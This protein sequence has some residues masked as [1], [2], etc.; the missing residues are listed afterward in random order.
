M[1][2]IAVIFGGQSV[3]HDVSIVTALSSVI[4][5]LELTKKYHVVAVYIAKDGAWYSDEALKDITIYTSG[6]IQ[7]FLQKNTPVSVALDGG[8]SFVKRGRLSEKKQK[9][10]IVFPAMH[11]T[12]GEDGALMGMLEMTNTPYVGC[13]MPASALAMDKVLAKTVTASAG[14]PVTKFLHFSKQ[15]AQQDIR[16]VVMQ[17]EEQLSYPLFV[18]PPHLGSSIGISQV[19]NAT[20]LRNAIEVALHYDDSVLIEEAVANL[21]EVTL[22]IM[23]NKSPVPAL[24]EK[25]QTHDEEFF[26]FETKYMRGGKKGKGKSKG[27][28]GYSELP[29]K[30]PADLYKKAEE[31]GIAVYKALGCSGTARVDML[32]DSKAG[33][34]YFNEVNPLPGDLYSHNWAQKGISKVQLVESLVAYAEERAL[35]Q[36][37]QTSFETSYLKQF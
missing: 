34:V 3:E 22:P 18:K 26:D 9:I 35:S 10:D 29:A 20:E 21:I 37:K 28:H 2:T 24:L 12:K 36:Q 15:D 32:I 6:R 14:I 33:K 7:S 13:T 11:G 27:V 4:K 23:G 1:K 5:P 31:T 17:C 19:R 30:L 16:H 25:P 8:L